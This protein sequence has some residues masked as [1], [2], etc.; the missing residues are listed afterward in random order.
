[1]RSYRTPVG[2]QR[3][4]RPPRISVNHD[5]DAPSSDSDSDSDDDGQPLS[6][7]QQ[8]RRSAMP[9]SASSVPSPHARLGG[10]PSTPSYVSTTIPVRRTVADFEES[11][12]VL[13]GRP[14][15]PYGAPYAAAADGVYNPLSWKPAPRPERPQFLIGPSS[16][17]RTTGAGGLAAS[18][19]AHKPSRLRSGRH[20]EMDDDTAS[21]A[22]SFDSPAGPSLRAPRS[23]AGGSTTREP[24]IVAPDSSSFFTTYQP[25]LHEPGRH[26]PPP[27]EGSALDTG[28]YGLKRSFAQFKLDTRMAV[29][30]VRS[31]AGLSLLTRVQAKRKTGM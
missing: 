18:L 10:G 7:A 13:I 26:R 23:S 2:I 21:N 12:A 20:A 24:P 15:S 31:L 22:S 27:H 8:R 17:L 14:V 11:D 28:L 30:R 5:P 29:H 1:M 9:G 25:S 4:R 16:S 19:K 3:K 6:L